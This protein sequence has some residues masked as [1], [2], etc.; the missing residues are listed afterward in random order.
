M[1]I[2][3]TS[4]TAELRG[5]V[6][7]D[8]QTDRAGGEVTT[9]TTNVS[10]SLS[11]GVADSASTG[12]NRRASR[13]KSITDLHTL[14]S[15]AGVL[16]GNSR[17]IEAGPAAVNGGA[18]IELTPGGGVAT[19]GVGGDRASGSGETTVGVLIE[20]DILGGTGGE[21]EGLDGVTVPAIHL[22]VR[23][24][25]VPNSDGPVLGVRALEL[26][27]VLVLA[28]IGGRDLDDVAAVGVAD[29]TS[30]GV[31]ATAGTGD[32]AEAGGR[33]G[34]AGRSVSP[35]TTGRGGRGRSSAGGGGGG[36]G[37]DLAALMAFGTSDGAGSEGCQ[38]QERLGEL[39]CCEVLI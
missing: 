8:S 35:G 18:E 17:D 23:T 39:H 28:R 29:I 9:N 14:D 13:A 21:A 24:V 26:H 15:E 33:V 20:G 25:L 27:H 4:T 11:V 6:N 10:L 32:T 12:S 7:G 2:H 22:A 16:S 34:A 30:V 5:V 38:Q 1:S 3:S 31:A 37:C 36:G 19:V